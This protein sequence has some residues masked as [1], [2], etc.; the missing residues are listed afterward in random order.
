MECPPHDRQAVALCYQRA[1][2]ASDAHAPRVVAQGAGW[3]AERILELAREHGVPIHEDRDL[4]AMLAACDV[5][6]EI[7]SELFAAVAEVLAWLYR[8]NRELESA[9]G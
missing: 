9:D 6:D 5:D 3:V 1:Q 4:V 7:P 8:Q 2:A